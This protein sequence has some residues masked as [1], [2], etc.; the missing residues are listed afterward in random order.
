MFLLSSN[1][2]QWKME[3]HPL[4]F[5]HSLRLFLIQ[6]ILK[7]LQ[8]DQLR[9]M[10]NLKL[11]FML[12]VALN[13]PYVLHLTPP[14]IVFTSHVLVKMIFSRIRLFLTNHILDLCLSHKTLLHGNQVSG[15][16]LSSLFIGQTLLKLDLSNSI[17]QS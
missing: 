9:L 5:F 4:E 1:L 11:L 3:F 6:M 8:M 16:I 10:F 13:M 14:N 7:L 12:R 17:V 15:K 2:D